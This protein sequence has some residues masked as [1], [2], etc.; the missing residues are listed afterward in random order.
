MPDTPV[1]PPMALIPKHTDCT[2]LHRQP[3][4]VR[5]A[6]MLSCH[7][8]ARC[9]HHMQS[10]CHRTPHSH[11]RSSHTLPGYHR[12]PRLAHTH[13]TCLQCP[14]ILSGMPRMLCCHRSAGYQH[15][16]GCTVHPHRQTQ[17]RSSH[18]RFCRLLVFGHQRKSHISQLRQQTQHH[19][20]RML[21]ALRWCQCHPDIGHRCHLCRQ[22]L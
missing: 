18:T 17:V 13:Y 22:T 4:Q 5:M 9:H 3:I 21:S 1:G 19:I 6:G 20:V 8:S 14:R 16:T 7:R 11:R 12:A 2:H 15:C 10:K